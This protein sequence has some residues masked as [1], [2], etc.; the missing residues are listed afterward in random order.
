MD[1]LT[2]YG[3]YTRKEV[4]D[5]FVPGG[6]FTPNAGTWGLHGCVLIPNSGHDYVFFVTYGQSQGDHF[7]QE[8]ISEDG[9][10][11]W[12]SQ[13]RQHFRE[14]RIIKWINQNERVMLFIFLFD[15]KKV[16]HTPILETFHTYRTMNIKNTQYGLSLS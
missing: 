4:H 2:L 5:Y 10:I 11:T 1:K 14:H 15:R 16:C 13:P 3:K 12:Q 8:G 9:V 6:Q 7:F